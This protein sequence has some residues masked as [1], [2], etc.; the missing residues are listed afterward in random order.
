MWSACLFVSVIWFVAMFS[1]SVWPGI[2]LFTASV[3]E[4]IS[5]SCFACYQFIFFPIL[6]VLYILLKVTACSD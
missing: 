5:V 4:D 6:T 1:V 2:S 3:L